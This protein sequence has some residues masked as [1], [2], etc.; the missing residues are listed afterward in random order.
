[1][2]QKKCAASFFMV[3]KQ[4]KKAAVTRFLQM[5][6]IVLNRE[7]GKKLAG[8]G[9]YRVFYRKLCLERLL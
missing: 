5:R 9:C 6:V 4:A 3:V 2:L 1:M 8:Y 7:M